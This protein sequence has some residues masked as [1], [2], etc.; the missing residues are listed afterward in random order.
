MLK[1]NSV[2]ERREP[3]V[4][5][6]P[7]FIPLALSEMFVFN[8]SPVVT[9][10]LFTVAAFSEKLSFKVKPVLMALSFN[11]VAVSFRRTPVFHAL[12]AR[13][14]PLYFAVSF[15]VETVFI[16]PALTDDADEASVSFR[17]PALDQR[18]AVKSVGGTASDTAVDS[19]EEST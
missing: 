2:F 1:Y 14:E 15:S 3:N 17:W 11:T 16:V 18:L 19:C 9:A 13:T 5:V 7:A 10:L 8:V 6:I 4:A 12:L